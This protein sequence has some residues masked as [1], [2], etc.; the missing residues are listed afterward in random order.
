MG[1]S[2]TNVLVPSGRPRYMCLKAR[3]NSA[4]MTPVVKATEMPCRGENSAA[5]TPPLRPATH[6]GTITPASSSTEAALVPMLFCNS[7]QTMPPAQAATAVRRKSTNVFNSNLPALASTIALPRIN[8]RYA[9]VR[10]ALRQLYK[11]RS[12]CAYIPTQ[13]A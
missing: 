6:T 2:V 11:P 13:N 9:P 1:Q 10:I 5:T 7:N 8:R 4:I 12:Q 3:N